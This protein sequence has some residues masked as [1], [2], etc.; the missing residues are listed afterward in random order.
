L[1][2]AQ[3]PELM[4]KIGFASVNEL[5]GRRESYLRSPMTLDPECSGEASVAK[6]VSGY[7]YVAVTIESCL[8]CLCATSQ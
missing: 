1:N 2:S 8:R 6:H 4:M 7:R 5:V 3:R